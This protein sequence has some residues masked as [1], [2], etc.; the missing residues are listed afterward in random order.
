MD[1][2]LS[3][4]QVARQLGRGKPA[5]PSRVYAWVRVGVVPRGG[6]ER[7][8]LA[9]VRLPGGLAFRQEDVDAFVAALSAAP[10]APALKLCRASEIGTYPRPARLPR[11]TA[12][13]V[14]PLSPAAP[15]VRTCLTLAAAR[16]RAG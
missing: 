8:R 10:A 4:R 13:R 14:D 12:G 7:V 11:T 1:G 5:S 3:I 6:G 2:L 15:G 9:A 16:T